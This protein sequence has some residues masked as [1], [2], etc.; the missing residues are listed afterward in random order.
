MATKTNKERLASIETH[1]EHMNDNI[2]EI[3]EN[4]KSCSSDVSK[5]MTDVESAINNKLS[6]SLSPKEK[7]QIRI[8]RIS[9][10]S[11]I[12]IAVISLVGSIYISTL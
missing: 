12:L 2:K 7:T 1:I 10:I 11:G 3:K 6:G 4:Y 8:A 5:R 9:G